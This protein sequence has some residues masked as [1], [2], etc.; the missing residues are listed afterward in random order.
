MLL[1]AGILISGRLVT[2]LLVTGGLLV[3]GVMVNASV[4]FGDSAKLPAKGTAYIKH[5]YNNNIV[6]VAFLLEVDSEPTIV[7]L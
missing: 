3:A 6:N 2:D 1:V 4:V 5:M 7:G